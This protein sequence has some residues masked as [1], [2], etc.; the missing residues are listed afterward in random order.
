[1]QQLVTNKSN[2]FRQSAAVWLVDISLPFRLIEVFSEHLEDLADTMGFFETDDGAQGIEPEPDH[3][4]RL[5]LYCEERP[6][7]QMLDTRLRVLAAAHDIVLPAYTIAFMPDKD[8]V[9]ETQK[10]FPPLH[11]GRFFVHGQHYKDPLP[12]SVIGLEIDAGRAF[13]TGEHATT[14]TCLEAIDR[15]AKRRRFTNMLDVGCGSGILAI[16]MA[17][18]WNGH[19]VAVDIDSQAVITTRENAHINRV[20]LTTGVSDGYQSSLVA[21]YAPY[22]FIAANILAR[23]LVAL[24]P[25]LKKHLAPGGVAI[26][27]G[28]LTNQE[29][30]VLSA[31]RSQGLYLIEHIRHQNWSTLVVGRR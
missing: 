20:K 21:K 26:L 31:Q 18:T 17:K 25:D 5:T 11:V 10:H 14:S 15:L 12:V 7:N 1:M 29:Q 28:L 8:W 9:T 4:W 27:S 2:P 6:D 13:G 22:D 23:P 16:A 24:A 19:I 30:L 3:V